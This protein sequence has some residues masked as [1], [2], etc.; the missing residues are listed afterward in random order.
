MIGTMGSELTMSVPA[1][2]GA[3]PDSERLAAMLAAH[4]RIVWRTLRRLGLTPA[5]A[6]DAAQQVFLTASD[7]LASVELGKE[8]AFLLGTAY[9]VAAN[10]RRKEERRREA[11]AAELERIAHCSPNPEELVERKRWRE[12]LDVVL[13]QM[14][15]DLRTVFVLFELEGLSAPEIA[16]A[17]SIPLGTVASRLRRA[18]QTF[19]QAA[20]RLPIERVTE[21]NH[22]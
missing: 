3:R 18:R 14:P 12:L 22:E 4:F 16:V 1:R 19:A 9:R 21:V 10:T 5:A 2:V 13:E 20:A 11:G 15:I 7:R 6:D 8:R 17:L